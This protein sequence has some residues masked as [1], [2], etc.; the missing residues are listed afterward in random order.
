MVI[1]PYEPMCKKIRCHK[2]LIRFNAFTKNL[3]YG[4]RNIIEEDGCS[5][6][7]NTDLIAQRRSSKVHRAVSL[8]AEATYCRSQFPNGSSRDLPE[9][10]KFI[11]TKL[12]HGG[13]P[14]AN[15]F[16]LARRVYKMAWQRPG[17]EF[18]SCFKGFCSISKY[19]AASSCS[20]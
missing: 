15:E 1:E 9:V 18:K 14:N 3:K 17:T 11:Q 6:N 12:P 16:G 2:M 13:P 20:L 10:D 5:V 7:V 19:F 4:N 8:L